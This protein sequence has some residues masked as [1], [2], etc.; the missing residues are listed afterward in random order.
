MYVRRKDKM[1][2]LLLGEE[3]SEDAPEDDDF[4]APD[5][6]NNDEDV[7]K[8]AT[9]IPDHAAS[10]REKRD[11]AKPQSSE[12]PFEQKLKLMADSKAKKKSLKKSKKGHMSA[13][14]KAD[15]VVSP[16][17]ELMFSGEDDLKG[18][19]NI[20]DI[21]KGEKEKGKKKKRKNRYTSS[22]IVTL[23]SW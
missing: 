10:L 4:F 2:A 1:R 8:V 18:D 17:F 15:E 6:E 14:E 13:A 12:S 23:V 9:F 20:R 7:H 16:G 21:V 19:Y 5:P 3:D 11:A 22:S